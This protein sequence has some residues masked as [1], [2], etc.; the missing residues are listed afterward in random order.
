[1]KWPF[2]AVLGAVLLASTSCE[3][4]NASVDGCEQAIE[5]VRS[6]RLASPQ[7]ERAWS[8]LPGCG[9]AAGFAARDAW[10][11]LRSVSDTVRLARVFDHVRSVRD[12]SLFAATFSVLLDSAATA[13]ARVYSAMLALALVRPLAEP[14]YHVFSATGP[15]D[16]CLAASVPDRPV[17]DG[18][19]LPANGSEQA[20]SAALRVMTDRSAPQAVR[21]AARCMYDT[22]IGESATS[23][24]AREPR[25]TM[26][27]V[28]VS[29]GRLDGMS[30]ATDTAHRSARRAARAARA[31]APADSIR[32]HV[33]LTGGGGCVMQQPYLE[34]SAGKR[35]RLDGSRR[36]AEQLPGFPGG[37]DP[38]H[39]M[40]GLEV[41]AFGRESHPAPHPVNLPYPLFTVDSFSVR[42][43]RETRVHDGILRG[44]R[45]GDVLETRDGRRLPVAN[46]PSALQ[47][48]DGMRVWIG[49]PLGAPAIAGVIDPAFPDCPE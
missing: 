8:A 43:M 11:S 2:V 23:A 49:E 4:S 13:P 9:S 14:D 35:F 18:A 32:G 3:Q 1:M 42:A 38:F 6:G 28:R 31:R 22:M 19:R 16:P 41:V 10:T 12:A 29:A 25:S 27:Y 46:V 26:G 24:S 39:Q 34:T 21:S 48:A 40:Q 44:D 37:R 7:D 33:G 45:H 30:L 17:R 15:H 47:K 36:L 20:T 5:T